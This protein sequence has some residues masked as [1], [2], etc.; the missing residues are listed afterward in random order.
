MHSDLPKRVFGLDIIRSIAILLVL[1]CH[2]ILFGWPFINRTTYNLLTPAANLLGIYGVELFFVLSG[3]LIGQIV[4]REIIARPALKS[5]IRFYIRR[6]FRTL[7]L[8]YLVLLLYGSYF[9][10]NYGTV[11]PLPLLFFIQNFFPGALNFF[12]PSWSISIEEWF[13]LLIPLLVLA[14][15]RNK[16]ASFFKVFSYLIIILISTRVGYVLFFHPAFDFGIKESLLVN[17]DALLIGVLLATIKL[18]HE[19]IYK[20]FCH[21]NKTFL[22]AIS[23]FFFSLY[24]YWIRL[25]HGSYDHSLFIRAFSLPI[26][27]FCFSFIIGYFENNTFINL[28]M[29]KIPPVR[30]FFTRI[31]KYSYGLY[32]INYPIMLLTIRT[33]NSY[34][35]LVFA[36]L[37]SFFLAAILHHFYE[38]PVMDLREIFAPQ[39]DSTGNIATSIPTNNNFLIVRIPKTVLFFLF[40][41]ATT[42]LWSILYSWYSFP[43]NF[44]QPYFGLVNAW[45]VGAYFTFPIIFY[46]TVTFLLLTAVY[47]LNYLLVYKNEK[48]SKTIK[49]LI[50]FTAI[51]VIALNILIYPIGYKDIF[52]YLQEL[53]IAYFYHQNP[54][55][56]TFSQFSPDPF[57]PFGILKKTTLAYGPVWLLLSYAPIFLAGIYNVFISTLSYKLFNTFFVIATAILIYILV[58]DQKK[59]WLSIYLFLLNPLILFD[60]ITNA[61]NDIIMTFFFL[62]SLFMLKKKP[63][64]AFPLLILGVLTKVTLLIFAPI[65]LLMLLDKNYP[66]KKLLISIFITISIALA[67]SFPFW[68]NGKIL[69]GLMGGLTTARDLNGASLL[70]L[71]KTTVPMRSSGSSISIFINNIGILLFT[72][73]G[74]LYTYYLWFKKNQKDQMIF[75]DIYL[76]FLLLV[77]GFYPW[78]FIPLIA[79]L[80]LNIKKSTLFFLILLTGSG[81]LFYVLKYT[82][83]DRTFQG[84]FLPHL[85]EF[86]LLFLPFIFYASIRLYQLFGNKS[87]LPDLMQ[88]NTHSKE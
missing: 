59:K 88:T 37:A 83:E 74:T 54:Y 26:L 84:L 51:L 32:L 3:F 53:R 79:I 57:S 42:V 18:Y 2:I 16:T 52:Y 87:E 4:F 75:L 80:C 38:K 27:A 76:L 43:K 48:I 55:V 49:L 23:I 66:K 34:M 71:V 25:I 50:G 78:Y 58:K 11:I 20:K 1:A 46:T 70:S 44:R 56:A 7:P 36:L 63:F 8:Y 33:Y 19:N 47:S 61:H 69:V 65:L 73:I 81:L 24:L 22:A 13:Y 5:V 9:F 77:S 14:F 72:V 82:L 30:F 10:F 6:W 85:S 68:A 62:L 15:A 67:L 29:N 17:Y 41:V 40:S 31:S 45:P 28:Q 21:R 60:A 35:S 12:T 39:Q 86:I 64:F